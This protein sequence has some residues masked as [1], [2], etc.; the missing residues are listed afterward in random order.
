[1]KKS[2]FRK[3]MRKLSGSLQPPDMGDLQ[4]CHQDLQELSAAVITGIASKN[5]YALLYEE[6]ED[7]E[8][9]PTGLHGSRTRRRIQKH[10]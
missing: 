2:K 6:E 3:L 5:Y 1:M 8:G 9:K 10:H 4:G 7:E